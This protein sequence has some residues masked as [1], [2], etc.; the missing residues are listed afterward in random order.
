MQGMTPSFSHPEPV[1]KRLA[2]VKTAY[3]RRKAMMFE[4]GWVQASAEY[5]RTGAGNHDFGAR[6]AQSR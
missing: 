5:Q 2:A 4:L 6:R 3:A 1:A